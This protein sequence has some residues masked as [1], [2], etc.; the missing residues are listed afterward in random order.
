MSKTPP[1]DVIELA[2][3][4][5]RRLGPYRPLEPGLCGESLWGKGYWDDEG[6]VI[7]DPWVSTDCLRF[8]E[9]IASE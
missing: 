1:I 7:G 4:P 3:E 5:R 2:I 9:D 8:E 6:L